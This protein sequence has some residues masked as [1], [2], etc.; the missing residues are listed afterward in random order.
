MKRQRFH[1]RLMTE[2]ACVEAVS[3]N[4]YG[5]IIEEELLLR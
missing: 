5:Y 4:E 1:M 2:S 3:H